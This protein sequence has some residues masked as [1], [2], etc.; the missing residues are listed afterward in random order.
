MRPEPIGQRLRELEKDLHRKGGGDQLVFVA[1]RLN[2]DVAGRLK[3]RE[4][5][6]RGFTIRCGDTDVAVKVCAP[7]LHGPTR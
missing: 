5:P 1:L 6:A 4:A 2:Q 3:P 7:V